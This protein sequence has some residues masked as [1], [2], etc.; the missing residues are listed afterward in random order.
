MINKLIKTA[1]K[2][3]KRHKHATLVIKGGAILA[4]GYNHDKT[5]SE[6]A[7]LNK[8]WPSKRVGTTIINVRINKRNQLVNSAPC[9]NC[10]KYLKKHGVRKVKYTFTDAFGPVFGEKNI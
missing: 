3:P 6:I 2:S 5:H 8:L 1:I 9:D 10:M 7:A 4:I